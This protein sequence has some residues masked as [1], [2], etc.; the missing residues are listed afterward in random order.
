MILGNKTVSWLLL[1]CH[2]SI[3][4]RQ[5]KYNT[6]LKHD[7]MQKLKIKEELPNAATRLSIKSKFLHHC[8]P[9]AGVE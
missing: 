4:C 1:K 5:L 3:F 9:A 8:L 6:G 7:V 2:L